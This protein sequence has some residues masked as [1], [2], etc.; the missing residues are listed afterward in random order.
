MNREEQIRRIGELVKI[1]NEAST[2]YEHGKEIMSNKEYDTLF[3]EL[4]TL[5]KTTGV[6]L[7]NSPTQKVGA[8]VVDTLPKVTHEYPALS[9]DKT[10]DVSEFPKVF[11]GRKKHAVV[12]W[13]MDGCTLVATYDNG[14]LTQLATRGN[15]IIGSVITHNAPYIKGLPLKVSCKD[16]LVVRGEAAMSYAEFDRINEMLPVDER[17][18]NP[19]NLCNASVQL[20]NSNI[21]KKREIWFHAFKLVNAAD[22][23]DVKENRLNNMSQQLQWLKEE[24]FNVVE[25]AVSDPDADPLTDY[26]AL[27]N[28]LTRFTARA[29][30]YL[31]PV[32]G[33]VV[34]AED[35]SFAE[36]QPGT[37]HNPNKLVGY[38]LK[39]RDETAETTLR[40]IEWSA[41]RTGLIN[42][43]AVFDPVELCG[44][45]VS[46][47]SLHNVSYLKEKRL[48]V[49]DRIT[50]YKANM[51]IPQVDE[52][53]TVGDKL[54]Y[55]ESHPVT[56]PCC[57]Q[58]T[59]PRISEDGNTE[60]AVCVN[61]E[62]PAK[63]V[64]KFVH[65]CERD[66]MNITGISEATIEKLVDRGY[67]KE[68]ADFW[69][70]DRYRDEITAMEGFGEKSFEKMVTEAE[71]SRKTDFVS[72]LH[73]LGI[74]NVGKGQAKELYRHLKDFHFELF[75]KEAENGYTFV[76]YWDDFMALVDKGY[77]FQSCEGIGEII[78]GSIMD[79]FSE[80]N[81]EEL[82]N[83]VAEVVFTDPV[84]QLNEGD[85]SLPLAGKIFV[86]TGSLS[87][88]QNREECQ[89]LIEKLGGKA[90]GSVSAKTSYLI[91][92]DVDSASGK[93]KKAK[94]LGVPI[95]SEEEFMRMING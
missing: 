35:V 19:R 36:R 49:N 5:E 31:F 12:M 48:R 86:I 52:N 30:R 29:D 64:K 1:L 10:K 32:D 45:T 71:N 67:I 55:A 25:Y 59:Q 38:A 8:E 74:P 92:N 89:N 93:N 40:A 66:C 37:G 76:S 80:E 47:A 62:C 70:L 72:F 27:E 21:L 2:A 65:F 53:L 75:E 4:A 24:G 3:D 6:I 58:K 39:W 77:D 9:L 51:I 90:A 68:Y 84:P 46:R 41:S 57:G 26:N 22:I 44:T 79:Y 95:I 88:F 73:A 17:Y 82:D 94:E 56:C 7:A 87:H 61:P 34:A 50:V 81:K 43:V 14:R 91:N 69:H 11:G 63:M 23:A 85:E 33:L 78:N 13:K 28:E 20:T 54:T 83:L 18:K 16:H 60:V 42:P 15:G